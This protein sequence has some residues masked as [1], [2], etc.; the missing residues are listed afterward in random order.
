MNSIERKSLLNEEVF[1]DLDRRLVA[2]SDN[3]AVVLFADALSGILR[4]RLRGTRA[5]LEPSLGHSDAGVYLAAYRRLVDRMAE[6]D[7]LAAIAQATR[8]H[9]AVRERLVDRPIQKRS[10]SF[11]AMDDSSKLASRV[12]RSMAEDIER[13]GWPVDTI[14]GSEI[15]LIERYDVS[16][17]IFREAVRILEHDGA[18]RTKRGPGG[19]LLV[20]T[21][22]S[23]AIVRAAGLALEYSGVSARQ[24]V[25]VRIALEVAAVRLA[26]SRMTPEA[27]TLLNA[28]IAAEQA[29]AESS[30]HFYRL[31]EDIAQASGCRPLS[32]FVRVMSEL[33]DR[34]IVPH[35]QSGD[36]LR[37]VAAQTHRAHERVVEAIVAGDADLAERRMRRHLNAGIATFR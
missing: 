7:R 12:A 5:R 13:V 2:L 36:G 4:T 31:H 22:D 21:P 34:H 29:R 28:S 20:A 3:S 30:E 1:L 32:L 27:A 26:V 16:R 17:A 10:V 23:G 37:E 24:L 25:D 35:N 19:G 9:A 15:E 18:V 8:M 11:R 6:G 14:F 33:I